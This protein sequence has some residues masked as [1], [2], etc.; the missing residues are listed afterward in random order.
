MVNY[1]NEDAFF[2]WYASVSKRVHFDK[3]KLLTEVFD[4]YC[5]TRCQ[6]YRL[7]A[8][9]TRSGER[10]SYPY[11]FEVMGCCGASTTFIYF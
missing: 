5:L 10:E 9:A 8:S 3:S 2:A 11:R 7:P 4:Q 6:E 1:V